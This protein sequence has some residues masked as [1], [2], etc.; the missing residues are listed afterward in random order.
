MAYEQ[1]ADGLTITIPTTAQ[2][3]W[4]PTMKTLTWKKISAHNHTGSGNGVQLGTNALADD[5]VRT[6]KIFDGS[7]TNDKLATPIK[8]QADSTLTPAGTTT[9]VDFST[10]KVQRLSLAS[11]TGAVTATL[12]NMVSGAEY[13][14]LLTQGATP[15]TVT[16]TDTD[17]GTFRWQS[18]TEPTAG[19]LAN[20]RHIIKMMKINNEIFGWYFAGM[21]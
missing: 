2:N 5:A 14:F 15:R 8:D 4:G 16:W 21:A 17:G 6:A 20:S 3:N 9:T 1:I 18:G 13:T 19:H 10:G 7:V 11:A 12:S